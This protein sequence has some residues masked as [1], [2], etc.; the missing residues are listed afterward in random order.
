MTAAK[1]RASAYSQL[2]FE[3]V[4]GG[5]LEASGESARRPSSD[6]REP[7]EPTLRS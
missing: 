6:D 2:V 7:H 4:F 1:A 3:K 5:T